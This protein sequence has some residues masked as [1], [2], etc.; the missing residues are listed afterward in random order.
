MSEPHT[1][2]ILILFEY[3]IPRMG[4]RVDAVLLLGGLVFV[5]EF[6]VGEKFQADAIA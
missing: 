5:L 3:S 6:K 4:K 2:H 1:S